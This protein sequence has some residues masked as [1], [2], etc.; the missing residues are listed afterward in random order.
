MGELQELIREPPSRDSCF[1]RI[2]RRKIM[3]LTRWWLQYCGFA[4]MD[5]DQIQSPGNGLPRIGARRMLIEK[6]Q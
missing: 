3:A 2:M 6:S 5:A 1:S 4:R